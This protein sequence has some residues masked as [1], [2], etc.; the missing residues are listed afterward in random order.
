MGLVVAG[1]GDM[2]FSGNSDDIL[3]TYALGSCVAVM[4]YDIRKNIG[5]LV[6]IA[7][8]DSAVDLEKAKAK[9]GHFADTSIPVFLQEFRKM[10]GGTNCWI[11]IAGGAKVMDPN[12]IFDIGKRNV[13][14]IR[15]MLWKENLGPVAEDV[16]GDYSRTVLF[17]LSDGMIQLSCADRKWTI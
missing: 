13:L 11:K 3:K 9:P 2:V 17:Q 5:G 16:G 14:A 15:K 4:I 12:S 6:H 8:P 1:I 7:L 10:G